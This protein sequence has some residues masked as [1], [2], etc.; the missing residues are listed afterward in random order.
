MDLSKKIYGYDEEIW[1]RLLSENWES[2]DRDFERI[3]KVLE[4]FK[5]LKI[6]DLGCG[7]GRI[8]LRLAS[9]GYRVVGV[10][11]SEQC[12]KKANA[13]A[14]EWGV[15]EKAEFIVGDYRK[16]ED[17]LGEKKFDA[18]LCILSRAW[19]DLPDASS[20]FSKLR[21][22]I[23]DEG[24]FVIQD[25][26][27]DFFFQAVYNAPTSLNW[28]KV[29]GDLLLLSRWKVDFLTSMVSTSR[30]IYRKVGDD[31]KLLSRVFGDYKMLSIS[32]YAQALKLAG[33]RVLRVERVAKADPTDL[34]LLSND[35]WFSYSFQMI[36]LNSNTIR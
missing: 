34:E 36:A 3:N 24:V 5:A 23:R 2:G 10:D 18:A 30:E 25:L 4:E 20:F 32:E 17:F 8:S 33:W 9:K 1:V 29:M 11:I 14:E 21:A 28:F 12:I 27:K 35:P 19:D 16:L 6:L 7:I 15:S 22:H 13:I 31:L 26:C